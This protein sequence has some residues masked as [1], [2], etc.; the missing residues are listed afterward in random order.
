MGVYKID[1]TLFGEIEVPIKD[2]LFE[3]FTITLGDKEMC[4]MLYIGEEF[5]DDE[6]LCITENFI[7]HIPEM[8]NKAR[9]TLFACCHEN[10]LV[11]YFIDSGLEETDRDY[12][13]DAFGVDSVSDITREEFIDKL[14][15]RC[16]RIGPDKENKIDCV[17]DFSLEEEYTDEL[18][19]V[20]FDDA[21]TI[22]DISHE[23]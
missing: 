5:L 15:V 1:T 6:T 11:S 8:Y 3:T 2:G 9:T 21:Y 22:T 14:S 16:I 12:L 19:V 4:T 10:K 20:F 23:S 17:F 13:I 7:E 18:L